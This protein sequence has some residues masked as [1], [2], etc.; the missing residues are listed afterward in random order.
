VNR[1]LIL[2][3]S[4]IIKPECWNYSA[5]ERNHDTQIYIEPAPQ[6]YN[7]GSLA[8]T[9]IQQLHSVNADVYM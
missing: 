1:T 7:L 9:W 8:K 4:V 6:Y 5:I 3:C 2:I